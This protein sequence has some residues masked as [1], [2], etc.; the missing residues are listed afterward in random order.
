MERTNAKKELELAGRSLIDMVFSWSLE[1]ALDKDL[2]TNK[3]CGLILFF[4]NPN[5]YFLNGVRIIS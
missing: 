4:M 2:Y 5:S 1:D 3:V